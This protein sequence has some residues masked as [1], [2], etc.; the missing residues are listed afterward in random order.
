[1]ACRDN[2]QNRIGIRDTEHWTPYF[3][4]A[5]R[6]AQNAKYRTVYTALNY[7]RKLHNTGGSEEPLFG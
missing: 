7:E 4:S 5:E 1:M 3:Y 6:Y 2:E